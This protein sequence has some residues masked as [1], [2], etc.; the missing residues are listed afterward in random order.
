MRI[1]Q[2]LTFLLFQRHLTVALI[3][4]S[5]RQEVVESLRNF[6]QANDVAPRYLRFRKYLIALAGSLFVFN[7]ISQL[8]QPT[9]QLVNVQAA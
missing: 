3:V 8:K 9:V 6:P 2:S 1:I 7:L 5:Q 4:L